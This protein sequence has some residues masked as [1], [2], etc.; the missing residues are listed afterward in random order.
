MFMEDKGFFSL[1]S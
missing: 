1:H